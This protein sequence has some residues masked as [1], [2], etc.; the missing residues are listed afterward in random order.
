MIV[1]FEPAPLNLKFGV[2]RQKLFPVLAMLEKTPTPIS[3]TV[4]PPPLNKEAHATNQA[5]G[6]RS[7]LH[8]DA[9]R[10]RTQGLDSRDKFHL[11]DSGPGSAA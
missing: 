9:M 7:K 11:R 5:F 3:P 8:A 10:E 6:V 2:Q 1:A 4:T